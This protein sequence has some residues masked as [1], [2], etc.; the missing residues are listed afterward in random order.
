VAVPNDH[1]SIATNLPFSKLES[2]LNAMVNET[3]VWDPRKT[4][5]ILDVCRG[6]FEFE[7]MRYSVVETAEWITSIRIM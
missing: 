6:E 4:S 2:V 1:K 5:L 7:G 3:V